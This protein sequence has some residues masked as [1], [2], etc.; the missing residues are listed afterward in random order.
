MAYSREQKIEA[1]FEE[2]VERTKEALSEQGFVVPA[3]VDVTGAF[4]NALG[5]EFRPYRILITGNPEMAY[6]MMQQE[7][8]IG[9]LMP[10]N[11]VVYAAENGEGS[12]VAAMEP[13]MLGAVDHPLIHHM[14]PAVEDVLDRLFERLA[15]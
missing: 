10:L 13:S 3:E 5:K 11:V 12:V 1:P 6:D 9:V 4:R 2:A 14:Q 15:A 8:N 7:P